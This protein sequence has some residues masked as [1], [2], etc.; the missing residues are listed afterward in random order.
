VTVNFRH[1]K[2]RIG[3][4]GETNARASADLNATTGDT[5][6]SFEKRKRLPPFCWF[7]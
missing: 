3:C 5:V 1:P 4:L 7:R 6:Q 2:Q